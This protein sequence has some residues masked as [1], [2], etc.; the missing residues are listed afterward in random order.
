MSDFIS[1]EQHHAEV[2]ALNHEIYRL[3]KHIK[4]KE[5]ERAL[6]EMPDPKD[7]FNNPTEYHDYN[8]DYSEVLPPIKTPAYKISL[9]PDYAERQKIKH[10]YAIGGWCAV[11]QFAASTFAAV[12]I[13]LIIR[14]L[15][16]G[17]N[18]DADNVS[19][20][21]YMKG[22]S[23]LTSLNMLIYI[24]A[25]VGCAMIGFKMAGV[26]ASSLVKTRDYDVGKAIQ[27]CTAAMF[28]WLVSVYIS[29]GVE[30]IF[31]KYGY[32]TEVQDMDGYAVTKLGFVISIVY[33]CIIAPVTEEFFFRGMLLKV[34][35]KANQ[36]FAVFATAVF[37]GLAHGNLPQF[38]LAFLLGLFLA[39]ITLK[40][41]SI[42][43]SIV[44][45]IFV[46][47]FVTVMGEL[48]LS[49]DMEIV[50]N[51]SL[52]A[53]AAFGLL[54]LLIFRSKDKLPATTPAQSK[55]GFAIA[56]TTVGVVAA[57]TIQTAYMLFL[58]FSKA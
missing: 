33:T 54:M 18:P 48:D 35:S 57:F 17:Q 15:L 40:H 4:D 41:G 55:R 1:E 6:S 14:T 46:N 53:L 23:I 8:D 45:H 25:N 16:E 21:T 13:V 47:T 43:P 10:F 28:I 26:K 38:L 50:L 58:V 27:Y 42:I 5:Q 24:A 52:E 11:L 56:K 19:I 20:T 37:F 51:L 12:V 30:D 36:R 22:S 7:P 31:T 39:H 29:L 2:A 3:T 34:F 44:V 49:G 32:S 9:E